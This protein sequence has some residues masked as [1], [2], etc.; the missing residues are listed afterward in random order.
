[1]YE[2]I[3]STVLS[4]LSLE[5][6]HIWERDW[7]RSILYTR[8]YRK[9]N[10]MHIIFQQIVF[11]IF[12]KKNH[13][14][15]LNTDYRENNANQ[16]PTRQ[17]EIPRIVTITKSGVLNDDDFQLLAFVKYEYDLSFS[18]ATIASLYT[19]TSLWLVHAYLAK[20]TNFS[21]V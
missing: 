10:R 13:Y 1:M 2:I 17:W 7:C 14:T 21:M 5:F 6:N 16:D 19:T 3:C 15:L 8:M 4:P 9:F 18:D 11:F 20:L 12:V